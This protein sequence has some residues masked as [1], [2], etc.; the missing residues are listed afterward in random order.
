MNLSGVNLGQ[1]QNNQSKQPLVIQ[2]GQVLHGKINKLYPDQQAEITIGGQK[3]M[4][5]LETSMQ[6]GNT[7]FFQVSATEPELTLKMVSGPIDARSSVA[8]QTKQLLDTMKIPQSKEMQQ[9]VSQLIKNEIPFNK[10]Q[11]MAAEQM[12]KGVKGGE[13]AQTI[14][15]LQKI[16]ELKLPITTD[17]VQAVIQ[18]GK[19]DGMLNLLSTIEAT[20]RADQSMPPAL[21]AQVLAQLA[22]LQA[23]LSEQTGMA[24]LG[25]ILQ[26]K[27]G[28]SSEVQQIMQQ[29]GILQKQNNQSLSNQI[30][31]QM[32]PDLNDS[33]KQLLT[34]NLTSKSTLQNLSQQIIQHPNLSPES[35]KSI[36]QAITRM[37]LAPTV[38]HQTQ[39]IQEVTTQLG[40]TKDSIAQLFA[41]LKTRGQ[42]EKAIIQQL[43]TKIA[44]SDELTLPQKQNIIHQLGQVNENS[45]KTAFQATLTAFSEQVGRTGSTQAMA[46]IGQLLGVSGDEQSKLFQQLTTAF[47]KSASPQ[48]QQVVQQ[49]EMQQLQQLTGNSVHAAIKNTLQ[50]LGL[51]LEAQIAQDPTQNKLADSLKSLMHAVIQD[52]SSSATKGMAEQFIAR[53]NGQQLLSAENGPQQQIIMQVPLQF[54][55]KRTEATLQWTGN[56]NKNGKIDSNFARIMF[57]LQLENLHETVI[58]MQVQSRVVNLNIFTEENGIKE[59]ISP[60]KEVLKVNLEKH[61]YQLSGVFFKKFAQQTDSVKQQVEKKAN[62]KDGGLDFRI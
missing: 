8:E 61:D 29:V 27:V 32:K 37:T 44:A 33:I 11:L 17:T 14:E 36:Q 59:L 47:Q 3:M 38:A 12:L 26:A 15:A 54:L 51:S 58:D 43:A 35:S 50:S 23:P 16:I 53:M 6:A 28:S 40:Q 10:E 20:I 31:A 30:F 19:K 9:L 41:Q 25:K 39:L 34:Q 13:R 22:K 7:H 49:I 55:G 2:Q 42:N 52:Q 45:V 24:L 48:L 5:K 60:L 56:K 18:G 57:Y 21:K 1:T 46:Q 62:A 4:A